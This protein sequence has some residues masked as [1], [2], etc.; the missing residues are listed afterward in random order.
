M[1]IYLRYEKEVYLQHINYKLEHDK[2]I[3]ITKRK[4]KAWF[5]HI[6]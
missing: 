2:Y 4:S 6:N 5:N 1:R 3:L